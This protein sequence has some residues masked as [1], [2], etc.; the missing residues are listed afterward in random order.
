MV[1]QFGGSHSGNG[2]FSYPNVGA[3][4]LCTFANGDQN[5]PVM[6]GAIQGGENA[7]G[8]YELVKKPD[9]LSSERHLVTS[10][11]SHI[12]MYE[13]GKISAIVFDPIRTEAKV[14]YNDSIDGQVSVDA[15]ESRPICE[16]VDSKELS[17][18]NCQ[19]V[20]DNNA[21]NGTISSSTTWYNPISESEI[22]SADNGQTIIVSSLNG[23]EQ[24]S[25]YDIAGNDGM[26]ND[27]QM[28][29]LT[30]IFTMNV[31]SQE[32]M[33]QF[34]HPLT[35]QISVINHYGIDGN[36]HTDIVSNIVDS[37]NYME[38]NNRNENIISTS[39]IMAE[40]SS[41]INQNIPLDFQLYGKTSY[42]Q[43]E[44]YTKA[45]EG[46]VPEE[47]QEVCAL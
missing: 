21:A 16:K 35:S 11:K 8:Q 3:T 27:G 43:I 34:I 4:V 46:T 22:I 1:P 7:F 13:N 25:F 40:H 33:K 20:L 9:E 26:H 41:I 2:L 28:H 15:V 24:N 42:K 29:E 19:F 30:N 23:E 10:G 32:G 14:K 18:I 5:L 17:N 39:N 45:G 37:S 38:K 31:T 12:E 36:Q 44:N 47:K 6:L